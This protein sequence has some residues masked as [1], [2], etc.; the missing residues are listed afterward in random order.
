MTAA[1]DIVYEQSG[2]QKVGLVGYSQ[3]TT[4]IF[5]GLAVEYEFFKDR[6]FKVALLAPCTLRIIET[7]VQELKY[8]DEM[9]VFEIGGPTWKYMR[10][11]IEASD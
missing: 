9:G 6:V 5:V 4:N 8:F 10:E 1:T 11:A 7:S 2:G 3:G